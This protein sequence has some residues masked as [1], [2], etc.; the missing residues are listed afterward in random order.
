MRSLRTYVHQW[1]LYII[2]RVLLQLPAVR[3]THSGAAAAGETA[4]ILRALVHF[5]TRSHSQ[6]KCTPQW[7]ISHT[8]ANLH[9]TSLSG[10]RAALAWR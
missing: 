5:L 4:Q 7:Q 1:S 9:A 8:L 6:H 10:D 2:V 3:A